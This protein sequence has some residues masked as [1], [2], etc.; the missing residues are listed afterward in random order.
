[1][2]HIS[3]VGVTLSV[4][5]LKSLLAQ[6]FIFIFIHLCQRIENYIYIGFR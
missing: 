6:P 4:P 3:K 5:D 2:C 1:M